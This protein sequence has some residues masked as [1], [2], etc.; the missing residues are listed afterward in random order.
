MTGADGREVAR[1]GSHLRFR[2]S[3]RR[4]G[5]AEPGLGEREMLSV[6]SAVRYRNVATHM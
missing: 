2:G 1:V 3:A 5:A 6:R 4:G